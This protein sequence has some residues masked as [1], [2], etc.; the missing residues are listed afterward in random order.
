MVSNIS[1][2]LK[3]RCGIEK[4]FRYL[5]VRSTKYVVEIR[6]SLNILYMKPQIFISKLSSYFLY[7]QNI[8]IVFLSIK[9]CITGI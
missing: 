4:G 3:K 6:L 2:K 1:R 7:Q 8:I 5:N 9:K